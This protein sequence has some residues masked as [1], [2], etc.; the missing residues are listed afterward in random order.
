MNVMDAV[1][2]SVHLLIASGN[3]GEPTFPGED[4][5]GWRTA[6]I[7]AAVAAVAYELTLA[8]LRRVRRV[9]RG[10]LAASPPVCAWRRLRDHIRQRA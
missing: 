6:L 2:A 8:G 5:I 3:L 4:A 1:D 9:R 7:A 10:P